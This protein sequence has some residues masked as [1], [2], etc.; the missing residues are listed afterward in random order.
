MTTPVYHMSGAWFWED[1]K[2]LWMKHWN[3]LRESYLFVYRNHHNLTDLRNLAAKW[4]N[5]LLTWG[6]LMLF[7]KT[8]YST[9]CYCWLWSSF[10]VA[11]FCL[12]LFV[13]FSSIRVVIG[14]K[15][16]FPKCIRGF[17]RFSLAASFTLDCDWIIWLG[18]SVLIGWSNRFDFTGIHL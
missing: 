8:R 15:I 13:C 2:Y 1:F 6:I 17:P 3:I 16:L 4:R 10:T 18:I 9:I 7:I 11:L 12:C 14:F 5:N